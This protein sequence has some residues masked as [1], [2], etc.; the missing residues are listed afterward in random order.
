MKIVG[1]ILIAL[2]AVCVL[3]IILLGV[4]ISLYGKELL[5]GQIEKSL[6]RKV[7]I[8]NVVF[9]LPLSV[10]MV[11]L[12]IDNFLTAEKVSF[13]INPLGFLAGRVVLGDLRF[14]KP[15]V[16]LEL[17]AGGELNLPKLQNKGK[18]PPLL[19]TALIIE[20]GALAFT[21]KKISPDGYKT[22]LKELNLKIY[23]ADPLPLSLRLKYKISAIFVDPQGKKLGNVRGS[24]WVDFGPRDMDGNLEI[25]ALDIVHFTPYYG[26]FISE[27]KLLSAKLNFNALLKAKHNDLTAECHLEI[28]D[29]VYLKDEPSKDQEKIP[30]IFGSALDLF[31][32]AQGNII[33]DFTIKTKLDNPR[34]SISKLKGSIAKAA[35]QNLANQPSVKVI[36]NIADTVEQFR[37]FFKKKKK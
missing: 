5:T 8:K 34:L 35:V 22:I 27:K 36:G 7:N 18:I 2:L 25:P 1:R 14:I 31:A 32:N 12:S 20:D 23:K 24:G 11:D 33:L 29:V 10:A 26:N 4:F 16:T 3:F 19:V 15:A 17:S 21:D 6:K 37:Q 13:S 30:D 28:T 9:S